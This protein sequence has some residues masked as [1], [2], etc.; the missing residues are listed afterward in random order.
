VI[1]AGVKDLN[2]GMASRPTVALRAQFIKNSDHF[3]APWV[4]LKQ[5]SRYSCLA[6]SVCGNFLALGSHVA[7][8]ELWDMSSVHRLAHAIDLLHVSRC[9][10]VCAIAWSLNNRVLYVG[11]DSGV[12]VAIAV[13]NGSIIAAGGLASAPL[14]IKPHP[15]S[16]GLV[17]V[18]YAEGRPDIV[19]MHTCTVTPG[20]GR[21]GR[22]VKESVSW[23]SIPE[24]VLP[25][26]PPKKSRCLRGAETGSAC[27]SLDDG[28]STIYLV[29]SRGVVAHLGVHVTRGAGLDSLIQAPWKRHRGCSNAAVAP[30]ASLQPVPCVVSS[31]V[32]VSAP[33]P[34]PSSSLPSAPVSSSSPPPAPVPSVSLGGRDTTGS[35]VHGGAPV[36]CVI[37]ASESGSGNG[38]VPVGPSV[39]GTAGGKHRVQHLVCSFTLLRYTY[40]PCKTTAV[41]EIHM[42]Q[43]TVCPSPRAC[44]GEAVVHVVSTED[45][46]R[47]E[48]P[49]KVGRVEGGEVE[50]EEE[51][52]ME[53]GGLNKRRREER[54]LMYTSAGGIE[55]LSCG[56]LES[57]EFP[58]SEP[59]DKTHLVQCCWSPD[60]SFILGVPERDCGHMK[61][62]VYF[63]RRGVV[64]DVRMKPGPRAAPEG[65]V[66][67]GGIACVMWSPRQVESVIACVT[68][69][70]RVFVLD[71]FKN[72]SSKWAG[73]MYPPTFR[74]REGNVAFWEREDEWDVAD[75]EGCPVSPS[76]KD[77]GADDDSNADVDVLTEDAG[78]VPEWMSPVELTAPSSIATGRSEAG[79]N[80]EAAAGGCGGD[81][82]D[83]PGGSLLRLQ[84]AP[85]LLKLP[86]FFSSSLN[87][88]EVDAEGWLKESQQEVLTE[89]VQRSKTQTEAARVLASGVVK[90]KRGVGRVGALATVLKGAAWEHAPGLVF[91]VREL[92]RRVEEGVKLEL[93]ESWRGVE[94]APEPPVAPPRGEATESLAHGEKGR[95]GATD[96]AAGQSELKRG[97]A[98]M[99]VQVCEDKSEESSKPTASS[100]LGQSTAVGEIG[101]GS[102]TSLH[103]YS[104]NVWGSRSHLLSSVDVLLQ[105]EMEVWLWQGRRLQWER[106]MQVVVRDT[107]LQRHRGTS[108]NL[109]QEEDALKQEAKTLDRQ[110]WNLERAC[111]IGRTICDACANPIPTGVRTC[112]KRK[113]QS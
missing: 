106:D 36:A 4:P 80:T 108:E 29:S 86:M 45:S 30:S 99:G 96:A 54:V 3:G 81:V 97:C 76:L 109:L 91:A 92:E 48:V 55:V 25:P 17:L 41:P 35:G 66:S 32:A 113:A 50:G 61:G 2:S 64:G 111:G 73:P 93:G 58:Y 112:I 75:E 20:G 5:S 11:F 43:F 107:V 98:R 70:G 101:V 44:R 71:P 95:V 74:L 13:E 87:T 16:A 1:V 77:A 9:N 33:A 10:V 59:V 14:S 82:P 69:T 7:T 26:L 88:Q 104:H 102:G 47:S 18:N 53:G 52:E 90:T 42:S 23:V 110:M 49:T 65:L 89:V 34:E 67:Y 28:G 31:L 40:T 21:E 68:D 63:F 24:A 19:D 39:S 83:P 105:A 38:L 57:L 12:L 78:G 72:F 15:H 62:N 56:G 94:G 100:L 103:E 85:P 79:G 8:V 27:W 46:A 22:V 60:G 6:W 37:N 84:Q 51:E